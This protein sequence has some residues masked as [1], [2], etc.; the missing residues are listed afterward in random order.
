MS[1]VNI[2][3]FFLYLLRYVSEHDKCKI[4]VDIL[5]SSR[6]ISRN[7]CNKTLIARAQWINV[8]FVAKHRLYH[9]TEIQYKN[10]ELYRHTFSTKLH[11]ISNI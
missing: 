10:L 9:I 1:Q 4:Y 11:L 3:V 2:F 6:D 5:L 7:H 8:L